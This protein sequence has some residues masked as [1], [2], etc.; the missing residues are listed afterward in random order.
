MCKK[1]TNL[2][3]V[4][5]LCACMVNSAQA[6]TRIIYVDTAAAGTADGSSWANAY[7][8][9][10]DALTAAADANKPIE[11]RVATGTYK[12][13]PATQDAEGMKNATFQL[14]NGV[15]LKGGYAGSTGA[16]PEAR[17]V[18]SHATILS[19]DY[20]DALEWPYPW[21]VVTGPGPGST[22]MV[23][24]FAITG[25]GGSGISARSG[26]LTVANCTFTGDLSHA[27][28][29]READIAVAH[30]TFVDLKGSAIS[31]PDCNCVVTECTF[32]RMGIYAA[33]TLAQGDYT[34]KDCTFTE[35]SQGAIHTSGNLDLVNCRFMNNSSWAVSS[36][37]LSAQ[38][39]KFVGNAGAVGGT[40]VVLA[41]CEFVGNAA[42]YQA[43]AVSA[44]G[45][46]VANRCIFAGN[47]GNSTSG[48]GAIL[49]GGEFVKLS[50]CTLVG[51]RGRANSVF[52][53][54]FLVNRIELNQCIIRDGPDPFA[55]RPY[56]MYKTPEVLATYSNI[57]GGWPGRGNIDT[58]PCFVDAGCWDP[59]GTP[60]DA[61]DDV[62]VTGDYH[63]RSQAGHWDRILDDWVYDDAT[64]LC[65][66]AGDPNAPV[67]AE[68]FPNGGY[69]NM[70]AYG[71][72]VE[73]SRTYFGGPVC[74]VQMA[75][76]I[77]GDCKV[78]DLDTA[79]LMQHW[80]MDGSDFVN[81]PPTIRLTSPADGA[82]LTNPTPIAIHVDASDPDGTLLR[83]YYYL[84][85]DYGDGL[86]YGIGTN[87][88]NSA[89]GWSPKVS[90]SL[91]RYDGVYTITAEA[92]DDE[93]A[94]T[95]SDPITVTLHPL[96]Q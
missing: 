17:D 27:L 40:N 26:N 47:S 49:S 72:T 12:P 52:C 6:A 13:R 7:K 65:I 88:N 2:F 9:L 46:I 84:R 60:D 90:W 33:C 3:L 44:D 66:D 31:A 30:C 48:A 93:G 4:L 19:G 41:D 15:T 51:N 86:Y 91:I 24:G 23:D 75:G 36:R 82:E 73:A 85:H 79:I 50:N 14:I 43:G 64:S 1:V 68:P 94:R 25:A 56:G 57:E 45:P 5:T 76:D 10:Q 78:D 39:C 69:I 28:A 34:F 35:N 32:T 18:Q 92:V 95:V 67:G 96:S 70:G 16:D 89:E 63:L 71:G 61:K 20:N 11:I 58:D 87:S 42:R 29:I 53:D 81:K 21:H 74:Q 54:H 80:L 37:N 62:W 59:N 77:N 83:V 38:S 55:S 22:A 8:E